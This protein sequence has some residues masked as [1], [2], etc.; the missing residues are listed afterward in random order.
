MTW[1]VPAGVP[2]GVPAAVPV[3]AGVPVPAGVPAGV[4]VPE[5]VMG[6]VAA[7]VRVSTEDQADKWGPQVQRERITAYCVARGMPAP[8]EWYTDDCSGKKMDRPALTRLLSDV[9][10]GRWGSVVAMRLDRF[11]RNLRGLMALV[12]DVFV[13][14]GCDLVCVDQGFDTGTA[15]GR[16]MMQLLGAFGEYE[17][18]VIIER[19]VAGK[20]ASRRDGNWWGGTAPFGY[21]V[22][23]GGGL[24]PHEHN[25]R[26]VREILKM[27]P[28]YGVQGTVA[29]LLEF[30]LMREDGTP[31]SVRTVR[32]VVDHR[33][34][35]EGRV[36]VDGES[37]PGTHPALTGG[38]DG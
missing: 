38:F 11:A 25:A 28:M 7:Y 2:A 27:A 13:P 23:D 6:D 29:R 3:T 15:T 4:T 19:V 21:R 30:R 20:K 1:K 36:M 24:V 33:Y 35:Y 26:L 37:A 31:V 8:A 18:R 32:N 5:A 12:D 9:K 16:L 17:G 10:A 22:A 34:I 14:A